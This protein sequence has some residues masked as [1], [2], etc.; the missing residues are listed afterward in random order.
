MRQHK[1]YKHETKGYYAVKVGFSWYGFFFNVFWL[2]F[3]SLFFWLFFS[4]IVL[5]IFV[6]FS[7][8]FVG[9]ALPLYSTKDWSLV[10]VFISISLLIGF[11]GNKWV[12]RN[13]ENKDY[14]LIQTVPAASKKEAIILTQNEK[15]NQKPTFA[16]WG[17]QDSYQPAHRHIEKEK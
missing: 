16:A 15:F 17:L 8:D 11:K 7:E 4:I 10:I 1:V 6:G 2:I 12:S 3:K 9:K 14:K 13:L 5:T